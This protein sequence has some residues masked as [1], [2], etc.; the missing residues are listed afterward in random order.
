[1]TLTLDREISN[2]IFMEAVNLRR[3][4]STSSRSPTGFGFAIGSTVL[5]VERDS[6]PR[7]LLGAILT[8]LK[9]IGNID[10]TERSGV[11][12][13]VVSNSTF[14]KRHSTF[15]LVYCQRTMANQWS[16]DYWTKITSRFRSATS[17]FTR[18]TIENS[19]V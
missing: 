13:T 3:A 1:M 17:V 4:I 19:T 9:I 11:P 6:P 15:A 12:R 5:L 14:H 8:R 2:L 18:K 10:I 7:R 16:C